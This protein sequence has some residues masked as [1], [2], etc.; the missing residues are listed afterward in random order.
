MI[1]DHPLLAIT[2]QIA[3]LGLN[4][5]PGPTVNGLAAPVLEPQR[6]RPPTVRSVIEGAFAVTSLGH[7]L[8]AQRV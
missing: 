5:G 6:R 1:N 2:L 3:Q 7:L 4:L 8:G